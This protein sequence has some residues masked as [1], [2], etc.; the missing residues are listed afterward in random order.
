MT[1]RPP[2][3]PP[4]LM[5]RSR[6]ALRPAEVGLWLLAALP[7]V[8]LVW[9]LFDVLRAG[10]PPAS[11]DYPTAVPTTTVRARGTLPALLHARH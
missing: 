1:A 10:L 8:L 3:A 2:A 6:L 11:W 9:I 7:A 5:S 4:R